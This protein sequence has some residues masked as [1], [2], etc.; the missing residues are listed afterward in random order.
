V[1]LLLSFTD[2]SDLLCV[3]CI[4]SVYEVLIFATFAV[5]ILRMNELLSSGK[6]AYDVTHFHVS[7]YHVLKFG[8]LFTHL[9]CS[10]NPL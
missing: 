9:A 2:I 5:V 6:Y 8:L 4:A 10:V 1:L 7:H 3:Y